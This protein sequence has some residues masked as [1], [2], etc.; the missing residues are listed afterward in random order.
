MGELLKYRSPQR[1]K[2]TTASIGMIIF[3]ASWLMLFAG[4]FFAY[5]MLRNKAVSW[6]PMGAPE[7]PVTL[8]ALNTLLIALSSLSLQRALGAIK[9]D[10]TKVLSAGLFVT[11]A[12]GVAFTVLQVVSWMQLSEQGLLPSGGSYGGVFYCLTVVHALHV[13][14]GLAALIG[15]TVRSLQGV[16]S[17]ASHHIIRLWA[18]YWHFVG[19][20][21]VFLFLTVYVM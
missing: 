5:G 1:R 15:L 20:I 3:V 17:A 7:L 11:L 2:E 8:G 14:V 16:F 18:I 9:K 4:F 21:W 6:P 10:N 13:L 19:G 12:L